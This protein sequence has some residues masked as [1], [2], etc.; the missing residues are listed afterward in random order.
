MSAMLEVEGGAAVEAAAPAQV[1]TGRAALRRAQVAAIL[2]L[3]VRKSFLGRRSLPIYLLALAPVVLM[4]LRAVLPLP[5]AYLENVGATTQTYALLFQGFSLRMVIFFGCVWIFTNLF[6]GEV[7]D[8]SLHYYLL[9]PLSRPVLVVGKYLAGLLTSICLF[10]AMTFASFLLVYL[11]TG[12][13][14]AAEFIFGGPGLAHLGAYLGVTV[15]ACLGY[16]AVFLMVGLL[17]R[18]PIVPAVVVLGWELLNFLMPPL[19]KKIS[20]I[21]YLKYLCPVALSEGPFAIVSEPPSMWTSI[22]GLLL[23]A[24]ALLFVSCLRIRRMEIRYGED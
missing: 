24:A 2:R 17:F 8:R 19:L 13:R 3:E 9:T 22:L 10:G 23:L 11:P 20:V 5:S 6:R 14:A 1:P 4:A 21:Q 12:R 7:L 15:L 16:G 18:N